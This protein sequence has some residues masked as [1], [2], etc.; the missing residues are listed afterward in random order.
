MK[1]KRLNVTEVHM[2]N[3]SIGKT[4][5]LFAAPIL[6][7]QILQQFYNIADCMVIGHFGGSFGLAA[8]GVAGLILSVIINFFIGFSVGVS[9]ITSKLFGAYEYQKLK[10]TIYTVIVLA[11]FFG[12]IITIIGEVYGNIFLKYLN[13]PEETL[14]AATLYLR[15]CMLGMIPQLLYNIGNAIL[16][17]LGNTKSSLIFLL[18]SSILNLILDVIFVIGFHFGLKGAA[19]ATLLSQ[20]LLGIIMLGKLMQLDS[21]YRLSFFEKPLPISELLDIL[22]LGIPSGMQAI[23]MSISS[24]VIQASINEFGYAAMSGMT[25]YAK[26][27]GFLYYP[28]FSYGMALT[29]FIGQNI[30]AKRIDRVQEAMKKSLKTAISITLILSVILLIF[31]KYIL[32]CFTADL[33]ILHNGLQAVY[34]TFP[35]YFLYSINQIYMGG[36]KGMGKT[37]FPMLCSMICYCFFRV[38]WCQYFLPIWWDMRVVYTSYDVSWVIMVV[39]LVIYYNHTI[40]ELLKK[41]VTALK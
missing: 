21:A 36:L 5:L 38:L 6:L 13:C 30:G 11:I 32:L 1:L 17:S 2:D 12:A 23:F 8:V 7:S 26:I 34:Y 40:T 14:P 25:V 24:L 15:I 31:A 29:G 33:D 18:F 20:W 9:A 39:L 41:E 37:E 28:A 16:R 4:L 35:C 22:R 19:W 27:E 10:Q 3:G